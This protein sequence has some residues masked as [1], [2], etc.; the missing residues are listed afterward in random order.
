MEKLKE[1][2]SRI[3]LGCGGFLTY[4]IFKFLVEKY[5]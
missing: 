5:F 2:I 3:L 1:L 4:K